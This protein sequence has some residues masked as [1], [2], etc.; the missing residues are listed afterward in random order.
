MAPTDLTFSLGPAGPTTR[1]ADPPVLRRGAWDGPALFLGSAVLS[2]SV[3]MWDGGTIL[4]PLLDRLGVGPVDSR[5]LGAGILAS[6][7]VLAAVRIRTGLRRPVPTVVPAPAARDDLDFS[8]RDPVT[9]LFNRRHLADFLAQKIIRMEDHG[10]S[11]ALV[12]LAL[13]DLG[14]VDPPEPEEVRVAARQ[15]GAIVSDDSMLARLAPSRFAAVIDRDASLERGLTVGRAILAGFGG[16]RPSPQAAVSVA[17]AVY[18]DH[19]RS[20]DDLIRLAEEAVT[21]TP[22]AED[23]HAHPSV[24]LPDRLP[25]ARITPRQRAFRDALSDREIANGYR[26]LFSL[27]TLDLPIFEAVPVWESADQGPLPP[28]EILTLAADAERT[29]DLWT[30]MLETA[31]RDLAGWTPATGVLLALPDALLPEALPSAPGELAHAPS[32]D[33]ASSSLGLPSAAAAVA[34]RAGI[35]PDRLVIGIDEA[36]VA[37]DPRR[38]DAAMADFRAHGFRLCLTGFGGGDCGSRR[39]ARLPFAFARLD[40]DLFAAARQTEADVRTA[41]AIVAL[42]RGLGAEVIADGLADADDV[43]LAERLGCTLGQGDFIAPPVPGPDVP[44]LQRAAALGD[45]SE[46]EVN[47]DRERVEN[48]RK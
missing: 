13:P 23:G 36:C 33:G 44:A 21:G 19:A 5:I 4:A 29:A 6:G 40:A 15:L 38:V 24:R 37:A 18:P 9:G 45:L 1:R 39:I 41:A 26:P 12:V 48:E 34:A 30:R 42:G 14:L 16:D 11:L 35:A 8:R 32:A 47:I 10:G 7:V 31:C 27:E 3:L 2:A 43:A 20:S 46:T 17:L 22:A 25:F 28:E